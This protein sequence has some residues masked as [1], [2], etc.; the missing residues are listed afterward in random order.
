MSYHEAGMEEEGLVQ[1]MGDPPDTS[2]GFYLRE[3]YQSQTGTK[4]DYTT[5][6]VRF[7]CVIG[8]EEQQLHEISH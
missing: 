6:V 4:K 8:T 5:R 7:W 1:W 2:F 3:A